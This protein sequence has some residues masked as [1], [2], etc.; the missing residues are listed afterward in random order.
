MTPSHSAMGVSAAQLRVA[1]PARVSRAAIS[2]AQSATRPGLLSGSATAPPLAQASSVARTT[3]E[4]NVATTP[5]RTMAI[6]RVVSRPSLM[7]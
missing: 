2:A 6:P 7:S 4:A 5:R 1:V 3:L